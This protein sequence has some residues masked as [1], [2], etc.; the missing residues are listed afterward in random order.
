M[1]CDVIFFTLFKYS[2][3]NL[4]F[5]FSFHNCKENVFIIF[6]HLCVFFSPSG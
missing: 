5:E 6:F 1:W 2:P 3:V 4:A